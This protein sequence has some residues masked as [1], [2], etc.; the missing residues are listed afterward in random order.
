MPKLECTISQSL[1]EALKAHRQASGESIAHIVQRALADTLQ[2]KHHTLFQISTSTALVEGLYQGAVKVAEIKEHGDFGLGTF[3]D[4]DG[5]M[6]VLDGHVYQA[7]SNGQVHE[8]PDAAL[9]PFAVITYF[10]PETTVKLANISSIDNLVEQLE[11]HRISNNVFFAIQAKGTFA[12]VKVRSVRKTSPGTKFDEV[13][14]MQKEFEFQDIAGTVV[15][16]WTPAYASAINIPG[17]HMHFISDDRKAGGHLLNIRGQQID[18]QLNLES[19]FRMALP[20]TEAFLKADLT[21]DPSAA[22]AQAEADKS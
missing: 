17:Y 20:E 21:K 8:A 11:P 7:L 4:V 22:L 18:L 12:W 6:I 5:E 13:A 15:G 2:I 1:W 3:E 19:D 16:F 9:V 10:T 14:K